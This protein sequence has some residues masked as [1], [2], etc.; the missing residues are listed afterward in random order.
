MRWISTFI[1]KLTR[2]STSQ[3]E[4]RRALRLFQRLSD[5]WLNLRASLSGRPSA[6]CFSE[7]LT[8]G[9]ERCANLN[10]A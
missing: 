10:S 2:F 5:R 1:E 7:Q 6:E 3:N 4:F 8:R 9:I